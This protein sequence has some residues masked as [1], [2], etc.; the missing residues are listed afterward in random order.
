M[1]EW[2]KALVLKFKNGGL[3][4][5]LLVLFSPFL[6]VFSRLWIE[7]HTKQYR[8]VLIGPVAIP[9]AILMESTCRIPSPLRFFA[10]NGTRPVD[11]GPDRC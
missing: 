7:A 11:R 3:R 8:A 1:A 10:L 4:P 6:L 9:V 2:F 5:S